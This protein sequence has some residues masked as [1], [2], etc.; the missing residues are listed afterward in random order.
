LKRGDAETQ[1]INE[2][3]DGVTGA[4]IEVHRMLGPGLLESAYEVCLCHELALRKLIFRRQVPV[5]VTYKSVNLDCGYMLDLIVEG[6]V[7]VELKSVDAI[8]AVHAAQLLTYL[9]LLDK[10]VGLLIN[11]RVPRLV[12]G[13]KRVANDL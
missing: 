13:I 3:T 6:Q 10:R 8:Q 4:A 7:I 12:E 5:P 11:F 1:R 2:I 9:R